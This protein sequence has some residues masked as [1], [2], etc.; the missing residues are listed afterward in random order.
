MEMTYPEAGLFV[1]RITFGILTFAHGFQKWGS[2][3]KFMAAWDLSRPVAVTVAL[4]QTVGGLLIFLGFLV[5]LAALANVVVNA[6]ILHS[7]ITKS[8][9]PF[10]APARHSWSI[11]LAYLAMALALALGGGGILAADQLI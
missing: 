6:A 3:S 2:M 5:Q 8:D 1:L 4:V 10:L 7:L 11:G 9:E